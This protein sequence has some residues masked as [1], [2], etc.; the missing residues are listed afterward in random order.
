VVP[1]GAPDQIGEW[2]PQMSG[3]ASDVK[4]GAFCSLEPDA[5]SDVAA[6]RTRAVYGQASDE[7]VLKGV[8]T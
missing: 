7:W 8:K 5:G 6:I 4:L 2:C 1:N 3:D